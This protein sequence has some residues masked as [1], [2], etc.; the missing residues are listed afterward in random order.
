MCLNWLIGFMNGS[1]IHFVFFI[2]QA[3]NKCI[4]DCIKIILGRIE[5]SSLSWD[6]L[7]NCTKKNWPIMMDI[8]KKGKVIFLSFYSQHANR[9]FFAFMVYGYDHCL[10]V[11][12]IIVK[13]HDRPTSQIR[14]FLTCFFLMIPFLFFNFSMV[15]V[16]AAFNIFL[17]II[18]TMQYIHKQ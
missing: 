12:M 11:I 14:W 16:V 15:K 7:A 9:S 1:F 6:A 3:C 10:P 18:L 5:S 4:G 13:S 8:Q 17:N 2:I